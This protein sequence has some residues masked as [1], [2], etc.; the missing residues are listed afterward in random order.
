MLTD[1]KQ[2]DAVCLQIVTLGQNVDENVSNLAR[3]MTKCYTF[4]PKI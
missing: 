1:C 2:N 3:M 4:A